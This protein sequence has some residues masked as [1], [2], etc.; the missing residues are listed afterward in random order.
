MT[1]LELKTSLK[2]LPP[3]M[4]DMQVVIVYARGGRM[5]FE[6]VA[7][8]GYLPSPGAECIAVGAVSEIKRRVKTGEMKKPDGYDEIFGDSYEE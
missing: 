4:N 3:D 2:K 1:L 5:Q 7:F 6:L 8:T